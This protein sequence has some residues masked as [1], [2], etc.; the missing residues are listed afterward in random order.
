MS[1]E[2]IARAFLRRLL[3]NNV[4]GCR[5]R[6]GA[7]Q[8]HAQRSR[9]RH[10]RPDC[11]LP[12]RKRYRVVI[13]AGTAAKDLA[14]MAAASPTGSLRRRSRRAARGLACPGDD[15][16]AGPER[17]PESLAGAADCRS[18]CAA[19]K[20]FFAARVG[21]YFIAVPATPVKTATRSLYPPNRP[22]SSGQRSP[23][24]RRPPMRPG[25]PRYAAPRSGHESLWPG[26][27]RDRISPLD[28]GLA[29]TVDLVVPA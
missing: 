28:A 16:R 12:R 4:D 6:Q 11:L 5:S 3:A 15:R 21:D 27:G 7:V 25:C 13:N 24:G 20:P 22:R 1:R 17:P 29:W 14:W 19:L 2:L 26:H 18:P 9:R 23:T 8:R 10:R